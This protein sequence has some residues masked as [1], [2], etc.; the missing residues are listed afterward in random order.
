MI[1]TRK[2]ED[3]GQAEAVYNMLLQITE[4][5]K[6]YL[7]NIWDMKGQDDTIALEKVKEILFFKDSMIIVSKKE[8]NSMY[9]NLN[10]IVSIDLVK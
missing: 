7:L 3:L 5:Y 9:F 10:H 4:P 6:H 2:T 8:G 1:L